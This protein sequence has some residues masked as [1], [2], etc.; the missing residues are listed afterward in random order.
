MVPS[1]QGHYVFIYFYQHVLLRHNQSKNPQKKACKFYWCTIECFFTLKWIVDMTVIKIAHKTRGAIKNKVYF[2]FAILIIYS[3]PIF[4]IEMACIHYSFITGPFVLTLPE[5]PSSHKYVKS[6]EL[7]AEGNNQRIGAESLTIETDT[8]IK[9]CQ[10]LLA[11]S[12]NGGGVVCFPAIK[13]DNSLLITFST[14][15]D[16]WLLAASPRMSI[17][18]TGDIR[19]LDAYVKVTTSD[20]IY[21]SQGTKLDYT[22]TIKEASWNLNDTYSFGDILSGNS[23]MK[24]ITGPSGSTGTLQLVSKNVPAGTAVLFNEQDASQPIELKSSEVIILKI[25]AG[26]VE[27][28]VSNTYI[29]TLI[30]P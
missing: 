28:E 11:T 27:G 2:L 19:Q 26:D 21:I 22:S 30:C 25:I 15:T 1:L 16:E 3:T 17:I 10:G 6:V 4:A 5:L 20:G 14:N 23:K 13:T 8:S 24:L 29:A 9:D 18:Y 7:Y 12:A